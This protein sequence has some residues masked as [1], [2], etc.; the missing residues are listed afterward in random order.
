MASPHLCITASNETSEALEAP[1][2]EVEQ[3]K[4]EEEEEEARVN[5]GLALMELQSDTIVARLATFSDD[6]LAKWPTSGP[7][8]TRKHLANN[9]RHRYEFLMQDLGHLEMASTHP[10]LVDDEEFK[11]MYRRFRQRVEEMYPA[12]TISQP[13][14]ARRLKMVEATK[15]E[16]Q[17]LCTKINDVDLSR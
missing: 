1:S 17:W 14:N 7:K 2:A 12:T 8:R 6:F 3:R 5:R 11:N 10:D 13:D 4:K 16:H 9:A 15:S